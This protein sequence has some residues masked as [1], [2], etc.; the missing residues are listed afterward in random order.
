M[1]PAALADLRAAFGQ[2]AWPGVCCLCDRPLPDPLRHPAC[3]GCREE[4]AEPAPPGC[5]QCGQ[6]PR[7]GF[8]AD[9]CDSC[10]AVPRRFRAVVAA[11]RH[12][13]RLRRAVSELKFRRREALADF[14]GGLLLDAWLHHE[15]QEPPPVAVVPAPI[16]FWRGRRRGFNQAARL[17]AP[18]ARA[19]G[20]PLAP[21]VLRRRARPPQITLT[22]AGRRRNLRGAFRA[23]PAPP[24]RAGLP[25]LLV[26]D[27]FTTGSTADAAI[28]ALAA[29][30]YGPVDVL[31][32]T[33]AR[34]D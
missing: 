22:P 2:L 15:A 10:S 18:V 24:E 30:G 13:G 9:A 8:A 11:G 21:G 5:P 1:I 20:I 16:P 19:L 23:C 12:E 17:A 3:S 6:F 27:V 32:L 25:L 31:T 28:R 14:L 33:R 29:A 26:D 7:L 34:A 4:L